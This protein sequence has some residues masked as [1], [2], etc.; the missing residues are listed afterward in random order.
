[1]WIYKN[2]FIGKILKVGILGFVINGEGEFCIKDE[3][4]RD[5]FGEF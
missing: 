1:M 3:G 5:V 4:E 2:F